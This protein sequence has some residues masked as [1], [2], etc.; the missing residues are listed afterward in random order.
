MLSKN[1]KNTWNEET[2][3]LTGMPNYAYLVVQYFMTFCD[4]LLI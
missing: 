3:S 2:L 1:Y 4:V